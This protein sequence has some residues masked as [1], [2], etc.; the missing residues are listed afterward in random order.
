M[1]WLVGHACV[2][3][4][5][6]L[7]L[8]RVSF[9]TGFFVCLKIR[10]PLLFEPLDQSCLQNLSSSS[11]MN[12]RTGGASSHQPSIQAATFD[13]L[14]NLN[15]NNFYGGA[16]PQKFAM[17]LTDMPLEVLDKIIE[18]CVARNGPDQ[19][20]VNLRLVCSSLVSIH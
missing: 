3:V 15:I 4:F 19:V 5:E 9:A 2:G 16:A 12:I 1:E 6:V 7:C 8:F 20:V 13:L 18:N 17:G 11:K 14:P 10:L